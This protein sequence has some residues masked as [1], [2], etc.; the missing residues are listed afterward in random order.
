M[1]TNN[2]ERLN[3]QRSLELL[4]LSTQMPAC[5]FAP[6]RGAWS[7]YRK[8][9]I[10]GTHTSFCKVRAGQLWKVRWGK[11][12]PHTHCYEQKCWWTLTAWKSHWN[13]SWCWGLKARW[14]V[15]D[16]S[17]VKERVKVS[18]WAPGC[19][20]WV[21][22]SQPELRRALLRSFPSEAGATFRKKLLIT[23]LLFPLAA[24]CWVGLAETLGLLTSWTNSWHSE[25]KNQFLPL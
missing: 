22:Q 21:F 8:T 4:I 20:F 16:I 14:Q 13:L 18:L 15:V 24:G 17:C 6:L 5:W 7:S 1:Q 9:W 23:T 3:L 19:Q 12:L 25:S 11:D 10:P 2:W